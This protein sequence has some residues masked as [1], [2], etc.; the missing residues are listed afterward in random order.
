ML[1][2]P[3]AKVILDLAIPLTI[4][5]S[6]TFIMAIVDLAMVGGLGTAAVAAVGLAGFANALICALL[7]GVTPAVQ[8]IVSRRLG[9]GSTEPACLPLNAGLLMALAG[10]VPLALLCFF[11]AEPA[12]A[13]MSSDPEVA[14]NGVPYLKA[15]LIGMPIVGLADAFH[16]FWAGVGR[17]RVYMFN[18]LFVNVLNAAL[19]YALIFGHFGLPALG[20][21]GAGI[22]S[23]LAVLAG[24]IFYAVKTHL[25]YK[26]QGLLRVMPSMALVKRM[27]MIGIPAVMQAGLFA[28]GY[29]VYYWIVGRMGTNELA[30]TNVL[31]RVTVLTNLFA[32]ALGMTAITLVSRAL[33][34]GDPEGAEQWGWDTAKIGVIWISFLAAPLVIVPDACLAIFLSD[35]ATRAMGLVPAQLTGL[36]LGVASMIYVFASTL[37][38]LGDGKRVM[39]VSFSTQWLLFLPG[40]WLVGVYMDGG[41]MGITYVQM[42]YG[43]LATALITS[44]WRDGRWKNIAI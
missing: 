18:I 29:L 36:C 6:S 23:T 40:V 25:H 10:G 16:G 21:T 30:V 26:G 14:R 42:A 20:A 34:E 19:G 17:T 32:Q 4:G 41:M 33:G 15:L 27:M 1:N 2:K 3:R 7:T 8:A 22:A 12:F 24:M 39:I 38:S 35:P 44:F 13:L 28:L 11:L 9:E 31:T 43:L 37:I 5:L